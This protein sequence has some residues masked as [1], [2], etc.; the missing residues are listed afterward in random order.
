[1]DGALQEEEEM[2]G[3]SL[4]FSTIMQCKVSSLIAAFVISVQ[5]ATFCRLGGKAVMT[6]SL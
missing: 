4:L 2:L 6:K 3:K 1:M 5:S